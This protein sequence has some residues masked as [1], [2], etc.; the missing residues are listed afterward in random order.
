MVNTGHA[1]KGCTTCKLRRIRCDVTRPTCLKCAKSK[2]ICLGYSG[3]K[4]QTNVPGVCEAVVHGNDLVSVHHGLLI[5]NE[6]W[7]NDFAPGGARTNLAFSL[8][9]LKIASPGSFLTAG[10]RYEKPEV[11]VIPIINEGFSTLRLPSQTIAERRARLAKYGSAIRE[12]RETIRCR[13]MSPTHFKPMLSF[14]LYEVPLL[15]T[16]NS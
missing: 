16:T 5:L 2:R 15:F 1:S 13:P 11:S 14:A 3:V 7:R 12:L 8:G 6:P 10:Y 9:T 4:R